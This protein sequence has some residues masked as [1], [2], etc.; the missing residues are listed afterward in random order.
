MIYAIVFRKE[1]LME[2]IQYNLH[3]SLQLA[4]RCGGCICY[5]WQQYCLLIFTGHVQIY[6]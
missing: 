4:R 1:D 3:R 2:F 5:L 6:R